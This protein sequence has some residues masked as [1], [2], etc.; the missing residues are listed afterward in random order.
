MDAG[1]LFI[2]TDELRA[3]FVDAYGPTRQ[4]GHPYEG[5]DLTEPRLAESLR[6]SKWLHLEDH[7]DLQPSMRAILRRGFTYGVVAAAMAG[8][9]PA[10]YIVLSGQRRKPLDLYESVLLSTVCEGLGPAARSHVLSGES[11]RN[12][13]LLESS[14]AVFRVISRSLDLEQTFQE[15]A[16]NAAHAVG[17]SNCL[18]L[19]LKPGGDDLDVVA[20]SDPVAASL[21]GLHLKFG[22]QTPVA[23]ELQRT[24]SIVVDDLIPGA[25]ISADIKRLFDVGSALLVPV[26]A[27]SELIGALILYSLGRRQGYSETDVARAEEV[28]EQ[29]AIAIYNARLYRD[30]VH[31]RERIQ[32]LMRRVTDIRQSERKAFANVIHDDI[33]Q[34]IVGAVYLLDAFRIES[35]EVEAVDEAIA[36]LRE[37]ISDARRLI[38]EL[39]PPV[40]DELGLEGSLRALSQHLDSSDG[41]VPGFLCDIQALPPLAPE[42]AIAIYKIAREAALNA[43][44]HSHARKI[45]LR[46]QAEESRSG[47]VLRLTVTDDG[48]GFDASSHERGSH[49]GR[50]MIEEQAMVVGGHLD[51]DSRDGQ[52]TS[53][54]LVVPI[55]DEPSRQ[56]E[57]LGWID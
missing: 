46:L 51:I 8:H 27:Q 55:A 2:V 9:T 11:I 33:V 23:D 21:I 3:E 38:W 24:R 32:L 30:L 29:A 36:V 31:S 1:A 25:R 50:A 57:G 44:R 54:T 5:L 34:A 4:R 40:L 19:E 16:V 39:R 41:R 28:A 56:S 42:V 15:I 45:V 35:R 13:A 37:T 14:Q 47:D 12:A 52:G 26:F 49:Y 18:L 10:A 22:G 6:R 43:V 53:V 17:G 48:V 7:H 20:A